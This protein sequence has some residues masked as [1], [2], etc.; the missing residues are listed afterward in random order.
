MV[1]IDENYYYY[2]SVRNEILPLIPEK[3]PRVLDVGCGAGNTL[4]W[5]KE[6]RHCDW[7]GGVEMEPEAA[8]HAR[9]K[10]SALYEGNIEQMRL[11]IPEGS[12][13][14]ILCLDVL[15]HLFDPWKVARSLQKLLK[16]GGHLIIS[17]PNIQNRKILIPLIFRGEWKYTDSGILDRTHI[18][19]FTRRGAIDLVRS[20]GFEIDRV[21]ITGGI[22]RGKKGAVLKAV[23]PEWLKGFYALQHLIRGVKPQ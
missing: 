23:F 19:F 18:R 9:G 12:L 14:L 13:D 21:D 4:L 11:P 8:N 22:S 7:I 15:E 2:G 1:A 3:I 6:L 20:A 16:P 5:I 10:L 17:L